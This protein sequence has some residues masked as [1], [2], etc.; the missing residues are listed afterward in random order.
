MIVT[1]KGKFKQFW[2]DQTD[3]FGSQ[4]YPTMLNIFK[5]ISLQKEKGKDGKFMP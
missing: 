4:E 3:T 5:S 2:D 1:Q